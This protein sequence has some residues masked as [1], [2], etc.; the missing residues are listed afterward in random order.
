MLQSNDSPIAEMTQT[1]HQ[2]YSK[3]IHINPNTVPSGIDRQAFSRFREQYWNNRA[4]D[5]GE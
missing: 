2:A 3:S 1:F 5:F 4:G